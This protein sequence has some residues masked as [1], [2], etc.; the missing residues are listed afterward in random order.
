MYV[1]R[2]VVCLAALFAATNPL[3]LDICVNELLSVIDNP[4]PDKCKEYTICLVLFHK[5]HQQDLS[6]EDIEDIR[7]PYQEELVSL[8]VGCVLDFAIVIAELRGTTT[9]SSTTAV[10]TTVSTSA[11][12]TTKTTTV[13]STSPTTTT[14]TTTAATTTTTLVPTVTETTTMS[15]SS[16]ATSTSTTATTSPT[17]TATTTGTS[18]TTTTPY[19]TTSSAPTST[20]TTATTSPTITA[21]TTGTSSTTTTPY[22]T[23]SSPP[24]STSTTSTTSVTPTTLTTTKTTVA[25]TRKP[26]PR[27]TSPTTTARPSTTITDLVIPDCIK[28]TDNGCSRRPNGDYP[29]CFPACQKG[30]YITCSNGYT[31]VRQCQLGWYSNPKRQKFLARIMYHP[32]SRRCEYKTEFCPRQLEDNQV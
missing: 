15:S 29:A 11:T 17:I 23:T 32:T 9:P 28:D 1:L 25:P 20:S 6:M 3:I 7:E 27:T 31:V 24:T 8:S 4:A 13:P 2:T 5:L 10:I 30:V 14:I 22:V 16:P 12:T 19:V 21:T 18:S 26:S